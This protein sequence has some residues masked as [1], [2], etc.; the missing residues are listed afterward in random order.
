MDWTLWTR[1]KSGTIVLIW[2]SVPDLIKQSVIKRLRRPIAG[3][4]ESLDA[5]AICKLSP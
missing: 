2:R 1:H 5:Q 4:L 3:P